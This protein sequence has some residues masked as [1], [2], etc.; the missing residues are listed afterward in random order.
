MTIPGACRSA[1]SL[2][3]VA[4]AAT[5]EVVGDILEA[6]GPGPDLAVVVAGGAH[7]ASLQSVVDTVR[8][9]LGPSTLLAVESDAVVSG[10]RGIENQASISLWTGWCGPV[11]PVSVQTSVVDN[12]LEIHGI[13]QLPHDGTLLLVAGADFPAAA[14]LDRLA[15]VRPRLVAAGGLV[16]VGSR[17]GLDGWMSPADASTAVG[18]VLAPGAATVSVA[19]AHRAVGDPMVVTQARGHVIEE[20]AGV[21]ALDRVDAL[22]RSLDGPLR[23]LVAGGLHLGLVQD[24][25]KVDFDP[26]DFVVRRVLGAVR[27]TRAIAIADTAAVGSVV[28]FHLHDPAMAESELRRVLSLNP[29]VGALVFTCNAR[30]HAMFDDADHDP[31][32]VTEVLGTSAVGG[33]FCSGEIGPVGP[34]SWLHTATAV[35]VVLTA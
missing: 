12:E 8:S 15:L 31:S 11:T 3:P 28:Q 30:G 2:H 29:G 22:V 35:V 20:L 17:F 33:L 19:Q 6:V 5:G 14:V 25:R 13:D 10:A 1:L 27:D 26:D 24:E 4:A 9:T 23:D 16:P 32:I 34:R 7:G 18:I 21:P